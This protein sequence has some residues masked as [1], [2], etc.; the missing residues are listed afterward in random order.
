MS[1]DYLVKYK[2]PKLLTAA[3][4]LVT[5]DSVVVINELVWS[6]EDQLQIYHSA[7]TS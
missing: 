1:L 2:C 5:A 4:V 6:Q 3:A 7:C